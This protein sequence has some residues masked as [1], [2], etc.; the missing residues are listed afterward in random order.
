MFPP[1]R[2]NGDERLDE[3]PGSGARIMADGRP[4]MADALSIQAAGTQWVREQVA[5]LRRGDSE[6]DE[7][8]AN[9]LRDLMQQEG[10]QLG[11]RPEQPVSNYF[12]GRPADAPEP[13]VGERPAGRPA[14]DLGGGFLGRAAVDNA[15]DQLRTLV[16]MAIDQMASGQDTLARMT[17]LVDSI[18]A[19]ASVVQENLRAS[20]GLIEAAVGNGDH[21]PESAVSL[22]AQLAAATESARPSSEGLTVALRVQI[23]MAF[24]QLASAIEAAN[25]YRALP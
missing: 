8:A 13:G 21:L 16:T 17:A 25:E 18:A 4:H 6:L 2:R 11:R 9:L 1:H 23:E 3:C 20:Q 7:D 22:R 5:A 15:R 14:M 10:I 12:P 24:S 19:L